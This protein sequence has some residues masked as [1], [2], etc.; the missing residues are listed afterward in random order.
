MASLNFLTTSCLKG[1]QVGLL[2]NQRYYVLRA[3]H[4]SAANEALQ[5]PAT[6]E[7]TLSHALIPPTDLADKTKLK[8]LKDM[9]GPNTVSNLIEFFWRDGFSRIHEIQV[10][11]IISILPHPTPLSR[12]LFASQIV[13][14][15]PFHQ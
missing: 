2:N 4:K 3:L 13:T 1:F 7:E 15:L 14:Y 5:I 6:E 10:G 12:S 9:P 11:K 8:S